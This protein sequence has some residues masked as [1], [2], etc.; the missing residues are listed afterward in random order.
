MRDLRARI[1]LTV[2]VLVA[3]GVAWSVPAA[4]AAP[5]TYTVIGFGDPPGAGCS[6]TVCSSLRAATDA[7]GSNPGSTI[8]LQAGRFKLAIGFLLVS[9]PLTIS[10]AGP[11]GATGT[12]IEQTNTTRGVFVVDGGSGT[13]AVNGVEITGGTD[14]AADTGGGINQE[15]AAVTLALS[16][17]LIDNNTVGPNGGF[18]DAAPVLGGGV[19]AAGPLQLTDTDVSDNRALGG[20]GEDF[21]LA[22]PGTGGDGGDAEGG[23]IY[24]AGPTTITGGSFAGNTAIAGHGGQGG[25]N[26]GD[27]GNGGLGTGGAIFVPSTGQLT[28]S[29]TS[30]SANKAAGGGGGVPQEI[31]DPGTNGAGEGGAIDADGTLALTGSQLMGNQ[32]VGGDASGL[33]IGSGTAKVGGS[34]EGGAILTSGNTTIADS[35]I[36]GNQATGG[37]GGSGTSIG[38]A[39]GLAEGGGIFTSSAFVFTLG[40]S[41]LAGNTA[42]GGVGGIN[43]GNASGANGAAGGGGLFHQSG[44]VIITGEKSAAVVNSTVSGNSAASGS[45]AFG[46]AFAT[47]GFFGVRLA[48][49]TVAGNTATQADSLYSVPNAIESRFT[50]QDTILAANPNGAAINCVASISDAGHNLEDSGAG[51]STCGLSAANGDVLVAPGASGVASAPASNGGPTQTL[52]LSTSSPALGAGGACTD[53]TN[54]NAA[55]TVDQRGQPRAA[56]CDIGAFEHQPPVTTAPSI[57]GTPAVGQTLTCTPGTITGDGVATA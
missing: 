55:L 39:G 8:E 6:G 13:F 34:G 50:V 28:D 23:G 54:N 15:T 22:T 42:V 31:G 2:A 47:A 49:D 52:A 36:S 30:F 40:S 33:V 32:A 48:S 1:G 11:G 19:Y 9:P 57:T 27:G 24:G 3:A 26:A 21:A 51:T 18:P 41:T 45:N 35:T 20:D 14:L 4:N 5:E 44:N 43:A 56:A 37:I 7:S 16:H 12:T 38:A 46:G 53:P 10:G 17:D 25:G 29:S